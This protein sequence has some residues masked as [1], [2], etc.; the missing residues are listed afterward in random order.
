MNYTERN[1]DMATGTTEHGP[2]IPPRPEETIPPAAD[3]G[4]NS[5]LCHYFG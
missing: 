5:M 1:R 2:T 4:Y 3:L